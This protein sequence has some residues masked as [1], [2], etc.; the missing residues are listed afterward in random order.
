[1]IMIAA[2]HHSVWVV[3]GTDR[4]TDENCLWKVSVAQNSKRL[5]DPELN[6]GIETI[7]QTYFQAGQTEASEFCRQSNICGTI[8]RIMRQSEG[9][10][11]NLRLKSL[12]RPAIRAPVYRL[13]MPNIKFPWD[14]FYWMPSRAS[15][16]LGNPR[17]IPRR[18]IELPNKESGKWLIDHSD[19]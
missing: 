10:Y 16:I 13:W 17:C 4:W 18:S 15:C 11:Q 9:I 2:M 5:D 3:L 6:G 14:A 8:C 12:L 1:M 7:S 19:F